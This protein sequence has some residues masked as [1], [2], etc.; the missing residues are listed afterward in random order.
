MVVRAA[1]GDGGFETPR[2]GRG[3]DPRGPDPQRD[4]DGEEADDRKDVPDNPGE[5]AH[6]VSQWSNALK[7]IA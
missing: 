1:R 5:R 2:R 7:T 6:H 3:A 4:H